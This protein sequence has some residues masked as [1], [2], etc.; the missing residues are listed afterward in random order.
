MD[1]FLLEIK[2]NNSNDS[3]KYLRKKIKIFKKYIKGKFL[4]INS[5]TQCCKNGGDIH[6]GSTMPERNLM[7]SPIYTNSIGEI[8][9]AKNIYACDASRLGF[10]SSLPHTFTVMAVIDTSMPFIIKNLKN[11]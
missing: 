6:Y 5:L 3:K 8:E 4:L 1:H 9:N 11:Q 2:N 7:K 10:I